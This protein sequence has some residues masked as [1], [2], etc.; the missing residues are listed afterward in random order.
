MFG[1]KMKWNWSIGYATRDDTTYPA[2][3]ESYGSSEGERRFNF[4]TKKYKKL[5]DVMRHFA[6]LPDYHG[7][8]KISYFCLETTFVDDGNQDRELR[9]TSVNNSPINPRSSLALDG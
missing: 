9:G 5:G 3:L 1:C 7:M 2:D 4:I 6:L 8:Y